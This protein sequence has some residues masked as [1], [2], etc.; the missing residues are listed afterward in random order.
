MGKR[1]FSVPSGSLHYEVAGAGDP[2]ILIHAGIADRRMWD[3]Q[4]PA[5]SQRFLV[6]RYDLRGF[7]QSSD[8]AGDFAHYDDLLALAD[9]LAIDAAHIVAVSMAGAIALDFALAYPERVRSLILVATGP[10][11]YDRWGEDIRRGWTEESEALTAGEMER[12]IEINL[13]MWVD[14]PRRAPDEVEPEVRARVQG[15]LEFNLPREEG[16]AR[17]LE[18]PASGRLREI[19]TPTLVIV[20]DLDQPDII[21]S[22][23]MLAGEVP[24]ARLTMME[25]VAHLPNMEKPDEFN[26]LVLEFLASVPIS[27][28]PG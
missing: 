27:S 3:N 6:V 17:D 8:P 15:M 21:E 7:G 9:E 10:N 13:R 1:F 19:A 23:K 28:P 5:F 20:G 14:G 4:M 22:S 12:A 25:G 24:G 11:G 2:L 26:R 18:P 16:E